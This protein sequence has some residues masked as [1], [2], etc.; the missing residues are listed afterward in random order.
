M[1]KELSKHMWEGSK[2]L[3]RNTMETRR[4][5]KLKRNGTRLTRHQERFIRQNIQDLKNLIPFFL[6]WRIPIFGDFILP[7][8]IAKYPELLPS[9]FNLVKKPTMEEKIIIGKLKQRSLLT[10][11]IQYPHIV[12]HSQFL[13]K[14]DKLLEV[15][16]YI[17]KTIVCFH[18]IYGIFIQYIF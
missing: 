2:G 14:L 5:I 15:I 13:P 9:T 8:F 16:N 3:F 1:A 10:R 6:V 17:K 18:E 12:D 11:D 7:I 4:L